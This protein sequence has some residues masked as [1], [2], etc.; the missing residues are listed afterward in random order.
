MA[1]DPTDRYQTAEE[2]KKA[3]LG[4]AS[5]PERP[6]GE[7]TVS[8]P[9]ASIQLGELAPAEADTASPRRIPRITLQPQES[10]AVLSPSKARP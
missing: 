9:P 7:F 5:R 1:V 6:T 4:A 10:E 2:F 3:L 8:P